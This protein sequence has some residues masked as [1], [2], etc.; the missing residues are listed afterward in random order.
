MR[1]GSLVEAQ[2]CHTAVGEPVGEIAEWLGALHRL[3][4]VRR[5]RDSE[6]AQYCDAP[7]Q[8]Q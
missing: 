6:E 7:A 3:I 4:S 2:R 5:A 8:R 1:I